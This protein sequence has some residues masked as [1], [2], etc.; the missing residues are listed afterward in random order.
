MS[1]DDATRP[2]DA[3]FEALRSEIHE[4]RSTFEA[5]AARLEELTR[6]LRALRPVPGAERFSPLLVAAACGDSRVLI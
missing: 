4:Y 3:A 6:E 1:P 2:R 5:T